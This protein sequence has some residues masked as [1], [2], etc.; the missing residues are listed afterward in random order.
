MDTLWHIALHSASEKVKDI[1]HELLVDLHL[2]FDHANVT[3][4]HKAAVLDSFVQRCMHELDDEASTGKKA[5]IQLISLFL[6]RYEGI[7]PILPEAAIAQRL[8]T[9]LPTIT[10]LNCLD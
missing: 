10:I 3:Y 8:N 4:E 6:D 1:V 5:A 9:K 2:K 7:K